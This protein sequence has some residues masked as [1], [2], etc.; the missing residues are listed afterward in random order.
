MK[1][2]L[3]GA[4]GFIGHYIVRHLVE[5]GHTCRCWTRPKSN[6]TGL[7][8][9]SDSIDWLE[10]E[11]GDAGATQEL[12]TGADAVVHAAL[13][14]PGEG[15][16]GVEGDLIEFTQLNLI[17]SLSLVEA[18][19]RT[20]A[21]RFVFISTC[22][23]HDVIMEDRKLDEAHPLW[24]LSHYGAYKA[25]VEQFVHSYGLGQGYNICA[26]RPTGVYGLHHRRT[27]SK[28][29]RLVRDVAEGRT[30]L[31]TDKG[32]K[33]V[34]AADVAKAVGILLRSDGTAGQA[35]NCYDSYVADQEVAE[36]AARLAKQDVVI[37]RT[38]AGP[39]HEIDT[40]KIRAL[41]M[42]FGG[43]KLLEATISELLRD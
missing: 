8:D 39:K 35:Y 43:K 42:T 4:T 5:Q 24:A 26:L 32:G 27:K 20:G 33:E 21:E 17:G 28:W 11:L 10:G 37:E 41:G 2:A 6:R 36:I 18:A 14:R 23:V 9:L 7:D 29:F 16:Q 40:S 22:A 38:N 3:T 25:A 30:D 34:H 1:I 19:R 31:V 15:F 13:F 12:V